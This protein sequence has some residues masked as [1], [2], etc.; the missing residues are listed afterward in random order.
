VSY[1]GCCNTCIL[2]PVAKYRKGLAFVSAEVL[3][4]CVLCHHVLPCM[5]LCCV[6]ASLLPKC[7]YLA[8]RAITDVWCLRPF[9]FVATQLHDLSCSSV[10]AA[11][12]IC[13]AAVL[14]TQ[15]AALAVCY[16]PVV[17]CLLLGPCHTLVPSIVSCLSIQVFLRKTVQ[18][19]GHASC[20]IAMCCST[21][22]M[23]RRSS[24]VA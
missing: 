3:L 22:S 11:F 1:L 19:L 4:Q 12:V 9:K 14:F 17:L 5:L 16:A 8:D 24:A 2:H 10:S 23:L 6:L 18:E 21:S 13:H 20:C 7:L 15:A